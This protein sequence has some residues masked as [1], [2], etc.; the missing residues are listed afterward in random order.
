MNQAVPLP[1]ALE[2]FVAFAGVLRANE[3]AAAPDQ[4]QSFI[5]AVGLL[6]LRDFAQIHRA[7]TGIRRPVPLGVSRANAGGADTGGR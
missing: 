1:R 5:T 2:P 4:T 3:F 7:A 6:G